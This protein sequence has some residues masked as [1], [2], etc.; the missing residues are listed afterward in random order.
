M[1]GSQRKVYVSLG[2]FFLLYDVPGVQG[3]CI[4]KY[5]YLLSPLF[6]HLPALPMFDHNAISFHANLAAD[7]F[8]I[9]EWV[10]VN[11]SFQPR[12]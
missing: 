12:Y 7:V 6:S 4:T 5:Y 3:G 10:G 2:F 11:R 9:K 1:E 8:H